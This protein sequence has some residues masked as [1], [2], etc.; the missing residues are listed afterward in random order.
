LRA[1]WRVKVAQ[2]LD[3]RQLVFVDEMGTNISVSRVYAWAPKVQR[4][5]CSVPRNRG[6]NTTLLSSIGSEGMGPS[7]VVVGSTT[8]QDFDAYVEQVLAP[9]L[10]AGQV[11]VMVDLTAHKGE[12]VKE[13]IE[14]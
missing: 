3:A 7:F 5:H 6:A 4:P 10:K 14:G 11:V 1:A 8:A 9:R 12:Q 13:L 2:E